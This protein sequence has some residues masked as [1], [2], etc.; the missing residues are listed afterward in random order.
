MLFANVR[1]AGMLGSRLW[2]APAVVNVEL[3]QRGG[4]A[5]SDTS[6]SKAND[7]RSFHG[8]LARWRLSECRRQPP[9][10]VLGLLGPE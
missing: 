1:S 8:P 2:M 10:L 9:D 3:G 5:H 6:M 7:N 4:A